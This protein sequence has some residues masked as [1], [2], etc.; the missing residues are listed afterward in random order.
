M[1]E[2]L[3]VVATVEDGAH[4]LEMRVAVAEAEIRELKASRFEGGRKTVAHVAAAGKEPRVDSL[5][6]VLACLSVEQRIAV[7]S[8]MLRSGLLR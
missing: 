8:E 2:V 5:D 1:G 7:K 6:A 3:D 4:A